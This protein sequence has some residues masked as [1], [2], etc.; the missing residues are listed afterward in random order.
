MVD[1]YFSCFY[2]QVSPIILSFCSE[3]VFFAYN[4]SLES[5]NVWFFLILLLF[6]LFLLCLNFSVNVLNPLALML[7]FLLCW[8]FLLCL[9]FFHRP[10]NQCS[11]WLRFLL[12][13][14]IESSIYLFHYGSLNSFLLALTPTLLHPNL[15][16]GLKRFFSWSKFFPSYCR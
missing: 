9:M 7:Y 14:G 13:L 12:S 1:H 11:I 5:C 8:S 6:L 16:P 2:H 10:L 15:A 4:E 3:W